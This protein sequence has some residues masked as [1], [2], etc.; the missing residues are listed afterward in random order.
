MRHKSITLERISGT[1]ARLIIC[2][3]CPPGLWRPMVFT[4]DEL[5]R[6]VRQHRGEVHDDYHS[7]ASYA[8]RRNARIRER[9]A[10]A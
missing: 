6:L 7:G 8:Q 2:H 9:E 5:Q 1:E 3:E 4:E 10:T